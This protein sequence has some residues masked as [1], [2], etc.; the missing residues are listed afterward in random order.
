MLDKND[1]RGD[2][3]KTWYDLIYNN[4]ED[5]TNVFIAPIGKEYVGFLK[6]SKNLSFSKIPFNKLKKL[7]I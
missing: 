7:F 5:I 6:V 1:K 3:N 2:S 4:I